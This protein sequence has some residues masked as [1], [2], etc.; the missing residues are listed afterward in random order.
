M[1]NHEKLF[2]AALQLQDPLYVENVV[3]EEVAGELHIYIN[4][5][6]GGKFKCAECGAENLNVHDTVDKVWR[7]LNFFQY[8]AFI[9]FR[10]P[11]TICP[12]HGVR[13]VR[14]PWA[15][16]GSGFTLLFEALV[17]QLIQVMPVK[18]V[19]EL[20]GEHDTLLWRILN[21]YV[22]QARAAADYSEIT[23]VGVDETSY[24]RRHSYVTLFVD[25]EKTQV[26]HVVEGKD[27]GAITSFKQ[28]LQ[29]KSIKPT[30]I[31]DFSA[32]MSIP[33]RK[34]IKADFPWAD[35]TFDKFHVI[36]LLNEALDRVRRQ[37]QSEE[38]ILKYSRYL[39]LSNVKNLK[40]SQKEKLRGLSQMNLKTARAY[41]LKLALQEVYLQA[42]DKVDAMRLL[43]E[44][45]RWAVRSRL[46]PIIEFAKTVK[47]N[48]AG[49]LN[50]FDS[51]LTNAILESINSIVQS[52]RNRAR[53]YRNVKTFTTMIYLLG[54][55]LNLEIKS[56]LTH[57]I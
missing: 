9:H 39:W 1:L 10:T 45:Y 17:L 26:V 15:A 38:S 40:P 47:A 32:D 46:K 41:R 3:F 42:S 18:Q 22:D 20:L 6:K 49:I 55:R 11:R 7:H 50:Y 12:E 37:E 27:A 13:M 56:G 53:G 35:I 21:R 8:K 44:W 31:T 23:K 19:A 29:S 33:F 16:P 14:V 2:T 24:R 34:G 43:M 51:R 25:L 54:G 52:A 5:H 4:F 30:Q 28:M 57:S 36:K 48:W